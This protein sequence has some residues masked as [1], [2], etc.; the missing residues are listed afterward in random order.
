MAKVF[1]Q[2]KSLT[3]AG[4]TLDPTELSKKVTLYANVSTSNGYSSFRD[5]NASVGYTVPNG[6]KL[7]AFALEA[8]NDSN[9]TLVDARMMQG[10]SDQGV[11]NGSAPS[12]PVN[13]Y[14]GTFT[15]YSLS[16]DTNLLGRDEWP[17]NFEIPAGRIP[18]IFATNGA[19]FWLHCTLEDV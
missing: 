17:T 10:T 4:R 11:N 14:G 8:K 16:V 2:G 19:S 9:S 6:K 7:V 15:A 1:L 18:H 5:S 3:K 12:S 13:E